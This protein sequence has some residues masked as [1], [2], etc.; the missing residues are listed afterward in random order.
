MEKL[1]GEVILP[2]FCF[3]SSVFCLLRSF[4]S[5]EKSILIFLLLIKLAA[6]PAS[7]WAD[8]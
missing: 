7:G 3:L 6:S 1:E 8:T 5:Y 4:P 2:V